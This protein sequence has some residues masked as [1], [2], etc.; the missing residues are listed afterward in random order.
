MGEGETRPVGPED[1]SITK[2]K[3]V[4][5]SGTAS[6]LD[7][8][9]MRCLLSQL[10]PETAI[11]SLSGRYYRINEDNPYAAYLSRITEAVRSSGREPKYDTEI[12][13]D[14]KS[15]KKKQ[16]KHYAETDIERFEESEIG[17]LVGRLPSSEEILRSFCRQP[18]EGE[19]DAPVELNKLKYFEA[20]DIETAK[21]WRAKYSGQKIAA[22]TPEKTEEGR[23]AGGDPLLE[24]Y[25]P[26]IR[27]LEKVISE[28]RAEQARLQSELSRYKDSIEQLRHF[29]SLDIDVGALWSAKYLKLRFG[30]MPIA[31][32]NEIDAYNRNPYVEFFRC[33][34]EGGYTWGM[35]V[36]PASEIDE[37]DRI[38]AALFFERLRIPDI[39]GRPKDAISQLTQEYGKLQARSAELES[40]LKLF[41]DSEYESCMSVCAKLHMLAEAF[42]L[43]RAA[44]RAK[45]GYL[46]FGWMPEK[47]AEGLSD[48]LHELRGVEVKIDSPKQ[49]ERF[50]PPR[51]LKTPGLRDLMSF[52]FQ[53]SAFRAM[54]RSTLHRW[55]RLRTHCFSASC[56]QISGRGWCWRWQAG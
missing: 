26:C 13:S 53:C 16:K 48:R 6:T 52:S 44:A 21:L 8:V 38:F 55:W 27:K 14:N 29:E 2:M 10:Q 25:D 56:S 19:G 31:S 28:L 23:P 4:S 35:Y 33:S 3:F 51:K 43:R 30:R 22:E 42:N 34:E 50:T 1:M 7:A 45:D 18:E 47:E 37:V 41:W 11:S 20:L 17:S 49:V 39:T 9:T 24:K 36:A 15:G 32:A 12:V 40:R 5:I 46:L 54:T